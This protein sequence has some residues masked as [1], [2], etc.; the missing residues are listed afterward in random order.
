MSR[1]KSLLL[2]LGTVTLTEEV[3]VPLLTAGLAVLTKGVGALLLRRFKGVASPLLGR[4]SGVVSRLLGHPGAVVSQVPWVLPQIY[5]QKF[6][7]S[8]SR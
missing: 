1:K 8:K 7:F 6:F 2:L 3:G 4:L 5:Y